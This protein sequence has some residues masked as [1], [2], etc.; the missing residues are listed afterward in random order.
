MTFK[1]V[2]VVCEGQTELN[3]VK[4]LSKAYFNAKEISLKPVKVKNVESMGGNVSI[5]RV[6]DHIKRAKYEIVTTLVDYYGF[7]DQGGRT[8]KQIED[9]IKE[10]AERAFL[11][12]Y[13]QMHETEALWFSNIDAI[14]DA[15]RADKHQYENLQAI[16]TEYPNPEDINNSPQ[17][18]PSKRLESIFKDYQKTMDGELIS[19]RISIEEMKAKCPKF[20][21]WLD[22]I[23]EMVNRLRGSNG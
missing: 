23:E 5:D 12:P 9:I 6:V 3:F 17:T 13:L 11:I 10:K 8:A 4:Y 16:I 22:S 18:A 19:K 14:K 1:N 21:N 15:K 7:K 2:S 20:S